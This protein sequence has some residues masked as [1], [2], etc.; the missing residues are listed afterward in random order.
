M[1]DQTTT[2][3]AITEADWRYAIDL[4][5]AL[6]VEAG[7]YDLIEDARRSMAAQG[8]L[9]AVRDH[10]DTVVLDWLLEAVSYQGIGDAVAQAYLER[11][12]SARA[13]DLERAL[14]AAPTC[15]K[16]A[17]FTT[18]HTCRF[19]KGSRTCAEPE[20]FDTCPLPVMRLRNGRLNQTA[21]ALCLFFRDIAAGDFVGWI[22]RQLQEAADLDDDRP[23]PA[24]L[25]QAL[26]EPLRQ[27]YGVSDKVL[28]MALSEL[29]LGADDDRPLWREAGGAMI[30]VD[31]LVHNWLHRTGILHRLG[32]DHPYGA[33]CYGAR[34]CANLI[35][36]L[37]AAIGARWFNPD[38][39]DCF[40]RFVQRAIW[41]FCAQSGFD[42]CNGN[43]IRDRDRCQQ[44][45]CVLFGMC[46]R[47][48]LGPSVPKI[49]AEVRSPLLPG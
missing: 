9:D 7:S 26:L 13:E 16:L 39:P 5:L 3:T 15:P 25:R 30:A 1:P 10:D 8:V 32:R 43:R 28:S 33:R 46:D 45:D 31:T 35:E 20:H 12:G 17:S 38:Y 40:P 42:Q 18:F 23:R 21:Y 44:H 36:D 24:R 27:V 37:S 4:T 34:G 14:A 49:V 19:H 47:V 11:H 48:Q 41:W 2:T 6:C 22:D 29:L